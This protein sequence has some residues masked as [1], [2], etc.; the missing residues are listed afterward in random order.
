MQTLQQVLDRSTLDVSAGGV[1][2]L[3][4]LLSYAAEHCR[5]RHQFGHPLGDFGLVR[6]KLAQLTLNLYAAETGT[7]YLAS[8]LDAQPQ[9][10]LKLEMAALKVS[11]S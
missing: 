9:R 11:T 8:L 5:S 10:D 7:Y 2:A 3:R 1:G 4:Y 6:S